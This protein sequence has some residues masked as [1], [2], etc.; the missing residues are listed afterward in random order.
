MCVYIAHVCMYICMYVARTIFDAVCRA[1]G[2]ADVLVS[3][4]DAVECVDR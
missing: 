4:D 2:I 3:D 1:L